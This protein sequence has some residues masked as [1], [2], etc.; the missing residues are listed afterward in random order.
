[1]RDITEIIDRTVLKTRTYQFVTT[2]KSD[3]AL[4]NYYT[5][6][7]LTTWHFKNGP[8]NFESINMILHDITHIIDLYEHGEEHRLLL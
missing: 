4:D 3:P 6:Y 5:P 1:M 2:G 7:K 8:R